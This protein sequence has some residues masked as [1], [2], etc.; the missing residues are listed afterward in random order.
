[1]KLKLGLLFG[2]PLVAL[3]C[4]AQVQAAPPAGMSEKVAAL[5]KA[6]QQNQLS[7]K[8]YEWVETV[9]VSKGG[10]QKSQKQF[11]CYYGVD[12]T[13][14]KIELNSTQDQDQGGG[15]PRGLIRRQ[16]MKDKKEEMVDYMQSANALIKKY[17]PPQAALIQAAAQANKISIKP[18]DGNIQLIVQDY[19]LP[20]DSL[21]IGLNMAK[22]EVTALSV[23][24]YLEDPKDIV[25]LKVS[26]SNLPDGTSY[27]QQ[28]VMDAKKKDITVTTV[29]SG[30]RKMSN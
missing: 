13:L 16:I 19:I 7:L 18:G 30:Y 5:K 28:T 29:N 17:I 8:Q 10:D 1:M 2:L 24:S 11:R 23:N 14:Q 6:L 22:P 4:V 15:R 9:T 20:G 21:D 3:L 26:F 12:G 25:T 27:T